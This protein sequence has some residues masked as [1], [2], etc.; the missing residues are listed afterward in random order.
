MRI[1]E[2]PEMPAR[3]SRH[4]TGRA[5]IAM[6]RQ[7]GEPVRV[8]V[9]GEVRVYLPSSIPPSP[10]DRRFRAYRILCPACRQRLMYPGK[11]VCRACH[12]AAARRA[13]A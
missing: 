1:E 2:I 10:R 4:K 8:S 12:L 3:E 5:A 13:A 6:V 11:R 7:T 9:D